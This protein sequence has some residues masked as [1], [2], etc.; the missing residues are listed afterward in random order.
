MSYLLLIN[1]DIINKILPF[2]SYTNFKLL[3]Q[4]HK[5]FY[6]IGHLNNFLK[7]NNISME[8][9][10]ELRI[11]FKNKEEL[12]SYCNEKYLT[13]LY[14]DIYSSE[15]SNYQHELKHW[16]R[17]KYNSINNK[18]INPD[19]KINQLHNH[20]FIQN[21]IKYFNRLYNL[22]PVIL[23]KEQIIN[24]YNLYDTTGDWF[25][26]FELNFLFKLFNDK[27]VY[28]FTEFYNEFDQSACTE[29]N[30]MNKNGEYYVSDS[31]FDDNVEINYLLTS[32][33]NKRRTN[34][35]ALFALPYS[36]KLL[37]Y[38]V[39]YGCNTGNESVKYSNCMCYWIE[40]KIN[41]LN[42]F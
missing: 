34:A 14:V 13:S 21:I 20:I 41:M 25:N 26:I 39:N 23:K 1:E 30:K 2:L 5:N 24:R 18:V 22:S 3:R 17:N 32:W 9:Y 7:L 31:D 12:F 10:L 38:T 28:T 16:S 19:I 29:W 33:E 42:N 40:Q 35:K 4:V 27:K 11:R 37:L 15:Y 8:Y 6:Q 36:H